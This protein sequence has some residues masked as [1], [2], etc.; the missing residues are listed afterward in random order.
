MVLGPVPGTTHTFTVKGDASSGTFYPGTASRQAREPSH[1]RGHQ[2]DH[3]V[4]YTY[5]TI[6][7]PIIRAAI[8]GAASAWNNVTNYDISICDTSDAACE[9]KNSDGF[10][11][12]IKTA[13]PSSP[14][15]NRTGCIY[16]PACVAHPGD[17]IPSDGVGDHMAEM[18][19]IFEDP[20]N[21]CD[22]SADPCKSADLGAYVWTD[23]PDLDGEDVQGMADHKYLYV[24]HVAIHEFGHT[25]GLPDFYG[26]LNQPRPDGLSSVRPAIMNLSA[27]TPHA[28][29]IAQLDAIY[30]LHSIHSAK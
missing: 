8:P 10:E 24:G 13:A 2:A 18:E 27:H 30:R 9:R 6:S 25:L 19:V 28:N 7:E 20:P 29:D 3:T 14:A 21:A 26:L 1:Y 17:P 22:M 4:G 11:V 16:G 5:G 15:D 23:D 12:T